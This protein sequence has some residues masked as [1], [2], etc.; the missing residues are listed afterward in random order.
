MATAAR[1]PC[2]SFSS[3]ARKLDLKIAGIKPG[4]TLKDFRA[5]VGTES[6]NFEDPQ[7]REGA[8]FDVFV[9]EG[10]ATVSDVVSCRFNSAAR[11]IACH[12]ECCRGYNRRITQEQ[13][14]SLAT[15]TPKSEV[16]RSLCSPAETEQDGPRLKAYYHNPVPVF[17]H[18]EGQGVMLVFERDRLISKGMSVYY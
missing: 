16:F 17:G 11:L 10:N 5:Q 6:L 3:L 7:S 8:L 12:K 14:D 18:D 9:S 15:G 1:T 4:I 2:P 13:Y